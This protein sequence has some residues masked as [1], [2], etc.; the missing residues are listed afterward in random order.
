M[1]D[2][3]SLLRTECPWVWLKRNSYPV[4]PLTILQYQAEVPHVC[5]SLLTPPGQ[6]G[7]AGHGNEKAPMLLFTSLLKCLS[8]LRRESKDIGA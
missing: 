3:F 5:L 2:L 8:K 6:R 1:K 7:E 4:L